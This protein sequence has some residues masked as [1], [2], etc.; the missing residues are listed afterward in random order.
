MDGSRKPQLRSFKFGLI[1]WS[2]YLF[3]IVFSTALSP[4][5]ILSQGIVGHEFRVFPTFFW[6]CCSREFQIMLFLFIM[7]QYLYNVATFT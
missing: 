6:S 7:I 5:K 1:H 3:V 2:L 4:H